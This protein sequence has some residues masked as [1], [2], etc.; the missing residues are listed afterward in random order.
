MKIIPEREGV[1]RRVL[2]EILTLAIMV[3]DVVEVEFGKYG[4][5]GRN[6][7]ICTISR[8]RAASRELTR[9]V[10]LNLNHAPR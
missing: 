5:P 9:N 4:G 10:I 1:H 6:N 2:N 8:G 7:Q 3:V